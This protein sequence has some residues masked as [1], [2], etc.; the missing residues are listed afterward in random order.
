MY[1]FKHAIIGT[2]A[3]RHLNGVSLADRWWPNIECCFGS[4][5]IFQGIRTSIVKKKPIAL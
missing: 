4:F 5:V 2:P 1:H 3:Q